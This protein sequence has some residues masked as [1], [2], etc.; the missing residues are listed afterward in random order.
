MGTNH[1]G[2]KEKLL[3][4]SNCSCFLSV[5]KRIVLQTLKNQV[6]FGK[7]LIKGLYFIEI[8]MIE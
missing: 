7:G 6:L 5:F 1:C 2:K 3:A 4:T 8:I